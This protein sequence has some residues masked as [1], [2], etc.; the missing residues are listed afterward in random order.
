MIVGAVLSTL[1][2]EV[3]KTVAVPLTARRE[4]WIEKRKAAIRQRRGG[5]RADG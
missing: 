4:V 5:E 1:G 2:G 3:A